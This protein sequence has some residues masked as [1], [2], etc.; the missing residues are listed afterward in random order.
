MKLSSTFCTLVLI[1][2]LLTNSTAQEPK[3]NWTHKVR[4]AA[5]SLNRGDQIGSL[6]E[7]KLADF[8]IHDGDDYREIAYFFGI[9]HASQV[10]SGGNLVFP[11]PE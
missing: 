6:E 10:Y 1:G 7:G 3:Q 8:A 4:I 5:Y 11:R 2:G 9:E